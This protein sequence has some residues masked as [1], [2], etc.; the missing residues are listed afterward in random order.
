MFCDPAIYSERFNLCTTQAKLDDPAQRQKIVAFVRAL[1]AATEELRRAPS[2][3]QRL[4]A[5]AA[6]LDIEIV[7]DARSY[8]TYPA[9]RV[10]CS[11]GIL[12]GPTPELSGA[13]NARPLERIVSALGRHSTKPQGQ[14]SKPRATPRVQ[15]ESEKSLRQFR[16]ATRHPCQRLRGGQDH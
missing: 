12:R 8:F 16:V 2:Q 13:R 4:V 14:G 11:M 1:I 10:A 6:E 9:R 5:Q 3:A 7:K 15:R